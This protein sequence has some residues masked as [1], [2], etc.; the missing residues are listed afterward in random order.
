[1][2]WMAHWNRFAGTSDTSALIADVLRFEFE[3]SAVAAR[4][5]FGDAARSPPTQIAEQVRR[6]TVG[7]FP[8][9]VR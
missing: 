2:R 1:M 3:A 8:R 7:S 6:S 9:T 4:T 5:D